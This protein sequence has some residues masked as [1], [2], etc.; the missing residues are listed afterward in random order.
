MTAT[1]PEFEKK[2]KRDQQGK[3]TDKD[4]TVT[5]T[6]GNTAA[7]LPYS[8]EPPET[9][10][11]AERIMLD[12]RDKLEQL[13]DDNQAYRVLKP[14]SQ[15][16][17]VGDHRY[18]SEQQLETVLPTELERERYAAWF[19]SVKDNEGNG[20][21]FLQ[22][23]NNPEALRD[24]AETGVPK[25]AFFGEAICQSHYVA[26]MQTDPI[27]EMGL[28][29]TGDSQ[30]DDWQ[31]RTRKRLRRASTDSLNRQLTG[32]P[33]IDCIPNPSRDGAVFVSPQRPDR[34][35]LVHLQEADGVDSHKLFVGVSERDPRSG[36]TKNTSWH[37]V[38]NTSEGYQPDQLNNAVKDMVKRLTAPKPRGKNK[39]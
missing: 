13:A 39:E 27:R 16:I 7:S 1:N 19:N 9:Y 26:S 15:V 22:T 5:P 23:W 12:A 32:R 28:T 37:E 33:D 6:T 29:G 35:V 14:D 25:D 20:D 30:D 2:I 36:R 17:Q 3:F 8:N 11:E 38:A 24:M 31:K 10:E 4:K 18:V 21:E 34:Q